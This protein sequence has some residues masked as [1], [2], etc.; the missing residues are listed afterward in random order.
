MS[1]KWSSKDIYGDHATY[2]TQTKTTI[3]AGWWF[4]TFF[5]FPQ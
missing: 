1:L 5:F 4:E 3:F 2:I